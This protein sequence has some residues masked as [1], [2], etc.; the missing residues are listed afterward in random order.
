MQAIADYPW[1]AIFNSIADG[2]FTVDLDWN[3]TF[4]N[5]AASRIIGIPGSGPWA[6]NAGTCSTPA[7][8]TGPAC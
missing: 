7:C 4:F 5:D 1:E 3:I 2:V 8:A 6:A